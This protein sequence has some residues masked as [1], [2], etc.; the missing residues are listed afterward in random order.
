MPQLTSTRRR[1]LAP[2]RFTLSFHWKWFGATVDG[3]ALISI[4]PTAAGRAWRIVRNSV[5]FRPPVKHRTANR[6][7]TAVDVE[8]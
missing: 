3:T 6:A 8:G 7:V 4:D 2:N 5:S 1:R